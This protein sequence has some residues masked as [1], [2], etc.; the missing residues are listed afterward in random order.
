MTIDQAIKKCKQYAE[1]YDMMAKRYSESDGWFYEDK[2]NKCRIE[3]AE[4]WQMM[5]WLKELKEMK[6]E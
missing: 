4:F 1:R 6:G 5:G 2:S 3:C